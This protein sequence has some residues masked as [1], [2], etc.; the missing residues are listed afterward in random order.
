M[1][2]SFDRSRGLQMAIAGAVSGAVSQ[3]IF[4]VDG[5]VQMLA[6][7]IAFAVVLAVFLFRELDVRRRAI[8]IGAFAFIAVVA[9]YCAYLMFMQIGD[10]FDL[11]E[12]VVLV[13]VGGIAGFTG[14]ALMMIG[15]AITLPGHYT[16]TT[17]LPV[18]VTGTVIG[19]LMIIYDTDGLGG[20]AFF[21]A[22]QG[23]VAAVFGGTFRP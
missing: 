8:R 19:A 14:C 16:L 10:L 23:G 11:P 22:W 15:A 17:A 18:V 20:Y 6:P 3:A 1:S 7:G 5:D 2:V 12:R 13:I 4:D 21:M 9:W